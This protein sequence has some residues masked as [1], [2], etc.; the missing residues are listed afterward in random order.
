MCV[1]NSTVHCLLI[2]SMSKDVLEGNAEELAC[3][4]ETWEEA[5]KETTPTQLHLGPQVARLCG[6]GSTRRQGIGIVFSFPKKFFPHL[7]GL[8][9]RIIL[10]TSYLTN[11]IGSTILIGSSSDLDRPPPPAPC[12][13]FTIAAVSD[14]PLHYLRIPDSDTTAFT[15]TGQ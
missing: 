6:G 10:P 5:E 9:T 13:P 7:D 15:S 11:S 12:I 4:M 1:K 14:G 8:V 3:G 2:H